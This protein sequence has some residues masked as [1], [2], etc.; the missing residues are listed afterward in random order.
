MIFYACVS[1]KCVYVGGGGLFCC[2]YLLAG[3]LPLHSTFCH[4]PLKNDIVTNHVLFHS[5][6][7]HCCN[8]IA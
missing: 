5:G 8:G 2:Y 4:L 7:F 1:E 6:Q 3:P